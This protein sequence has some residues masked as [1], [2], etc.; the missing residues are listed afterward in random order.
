L[1]ANPSVGAAI[2]REPRIR[3]KPQDS[4][5]PPSL[6]LPK[7]ALMK[8]HSQ[9]RKGRASVDNQIYHISTATHDWRPLFLDFNC[10]RV[11]IQCLKYES[12]ARHLDTLAFVVMPDHLHWLLSLSPGRS[13]SECVKNVKCNSARMINRRLGSSGRVWMTAFYDRAIRREEDIAAVARYI[14]ANPLRAGIVNS[15]REYPLW[16]AKWV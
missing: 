4:P 5:V 3:T 16:D 2:G 14:V 15:L 10:G 9:L 12:D 13:L 6:N 11:V 8:G 7:N 1:A